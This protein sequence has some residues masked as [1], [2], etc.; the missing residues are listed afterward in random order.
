MNYELCSLFISHSSQLLRQFYRLR[1]QFIGTAFLSDSPIRA[2]ENLK[3]LDTG[4]Q[5]SSVR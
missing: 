5:P 2:D 3:P 4:S 1:Q